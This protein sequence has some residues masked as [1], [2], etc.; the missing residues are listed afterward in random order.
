MRQGQI[1]LLFFHTKVHV[2]FSFTLVYIFELFVSTSR[3][4]RQFTRSLSPA[5][6]DVIVDILYKHHNARGTWHTSCFPLPGIT[7]ANDECAMYQ[8]TW[9]LVPSKSGSNGP[10]SLQAQSCINRPTDYALWQYDPIQSSMALS[11]ISFR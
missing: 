7:G 6:N 10:V 3:V 1:G 8:F 4:F 11:T 9:D 2:K 5:L